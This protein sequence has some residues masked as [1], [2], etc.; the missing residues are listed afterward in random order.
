MWNC[1]ETMV[2]IGEIKEKVLCEVGAGKPCKGTVSLA[3]HITLLLFVSAAGGW[4]KPLA[5]FPLKTVPPLHPDILTQF[6]IAG[7]EKGWMD[8]RIFKNIIENWF[9][10]EL[11][12]SRSLESKL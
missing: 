2:N 10:S 3:E 11:D 4:L 6:N 9:A 12:T 1:D 5:I 7:Q 8:G